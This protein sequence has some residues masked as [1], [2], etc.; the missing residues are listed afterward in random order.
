MNIR[1]HQSKKM[2]LMCKHIL[3]ISKSMNDDELKVFEHCLKITIEDL[4]LNNED[5]TDIIKE[6]EEVLKDNSNQSISKAVE[7]N[8]KVKE[9]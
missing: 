9:A 2:D 7:Y 5:K 1:E 3:D 4:K 6:I 8:I